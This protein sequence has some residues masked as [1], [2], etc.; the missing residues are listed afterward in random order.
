MENNKNLQEK[1]RGRQQYLFKDQLIY[2]WDQTIEDVNVYIQ[3]PKYVL[4]KYQSE[5]KKS[6]QPGQQL[7]KLEVQIQP[8]HLKIGVKGNPA[9]LDVIL[10]NEI[11]K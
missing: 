8:Q 10:F 9:Y 7:P 5:I 3:P 6:L 2:E 11:I 4:E 1:A